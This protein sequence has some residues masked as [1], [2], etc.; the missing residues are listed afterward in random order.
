MSKKKT[1][2]K[3][4]IDMLLKLNIK[5]AIEDSNI[6][7]RMIDN[8]IRFYQTLIEHLE[9]NKPLFFQ[10]KKLIEYNNK[11]EEYENKI[12]EL[13]TQLGQEVELIDKLY[14]TSVK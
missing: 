8:R 7:I 13:Y 14:S 2:D 3:E 9:D 5:Y 11:K 6:N 12:Y 1:E 4:L 10:K